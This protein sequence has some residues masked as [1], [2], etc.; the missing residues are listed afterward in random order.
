MKR[1]DC[2]YIALET[3]DF[4]RS[5]RDCRRKLKALLA[6]YNPHSS[7]ILELD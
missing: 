5:R 7:I 1:I 6:D 2:Q 4:Y 3:Y